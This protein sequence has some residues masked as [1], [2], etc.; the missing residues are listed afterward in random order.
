MKNRP[1]TIREVANILGVS[2][3]TLRRWDQRGSFVPT[4]TAGNQRR[5]TQEQINEFKT[6]SSA[7][8]KADKAKLK[9]AGLEAIH[10]PFFKPET[11][12]EFK[13]AQGLP[14]ALRGLP[15]NSFLKH[16]FLLKHNLGYEADF[17]KDKVEF[18]ESL[19]KS[20]EPPSFARPPLAKL[21]M[22]RVGLA[23]M[24]LVL[25]LSFAGAVLMTRYSVVSGLATRLRQG[26]GGRGEQF[27]KFIENLPHL[28]Q[29]SSGQAKD[30]SFL[31]QDNQAVLAA[32]TGDSD[33]I[34][35]VNVPSFFSQSVGIGTTTVDPA[36]ILD[37][38]SQ[39]KGFLA[40]RMT[41]IQRDAITSPPAGLFV[42]NTDTNHYNMHNGTA[43]QGVFTSIGDSTTGEAFTEEGTS[44]TALYFY[45]TDG[46]GKLT[47]ANLSGARIYTLPDATGTIVT[48][49]NLTA[50]TAVGTITSG[51]WN[52]TA[53]T[54]ANGGT[55]ATTL[56][57]I[58][59]GNGTSPVTALTTS[60]GISGAIS[61]ETGTGAL[62]FGTSPA[63]TT[64]L[65]TAST[66]FALLNTAVTT[67][68][69]AGA[70]TTLSI[71]AATGT[72]T[73]N[74]ATTA[75]TGAL[76]ANGDVTLGNAIT[77][78]ITF[79]GR[80]AADSD[81]IPIGTTG[82][83]DLGSAALPWD[84]LYADNVFAALTGTSG[85]WQRSN[86]AISPTNI[87]DDLLLG[88]TSTSSAKF[89]FIN[90]AG[91]N[92]TA[93]IS[94]NLSLAVPTG[95]AP[96]ATL[97]LFNNG[98]LNIQRSAGGDSGLATTMFFQSNGNV[99]IGTTAPSN[100]GLDVAGA[101]AKIR[102]HDYQDNAD[103]GNFEMFKARGTEVLPAAV[104]NSDQLGVMG[105]LGYDGNSYEFTGYM[106]S[107]VAGAVS[108]GN[109]PGDLRFSTNPTDG[110]VERMRIT[111]SGNMGIGNTTPL[112][113]L[114]VTGT[115]SLS[116]NLSLRGAGTAHT[117]NILDNGTLNFQRYPSGDAA[118]NSSVLF[119]QNNGNVGIGNTAPG[120]MLSV[121]S[122]TPT[123]VSSAGLITVANT[124]D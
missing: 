11:P 55:G 90:M 43:W 77:D 73:L 61:D 88:A 111:S 28:R 8:A 25:I 106:Q 74:N 48:T 20:S 85:Y 50:I 21:N 64:S 114:D 2:T 87:T 57:G 93:T 37:I 80:V 91:G 16:H 47:T 76:T 56:T 110:A 86:N 18:K 13:P 81:L 97:N 83:N 99:G 5:Y 68:N 7:K 92:P 35:N 17:T 40:P 89:G 117:F 120:A 98:T 51:V 38:V 59:L 30:L 66:T 82:T 96:S 69:F 113:A 62:V 63:I 42:Y 26:F 4:R 121:G 10:E 65:T 103:A 3:K 84:N 116:A 105:F 72:V 29:G 101:N 119:L 24:G 60:L 104:Q 27:A 44:G 58:L 46:R 32:A 6:S 70:A 67:I 31:P 124:T 109:V 41:T 107:Y 108:D 49:G 45:D 79:T 19:E 78:N 9:A 53:V 75:I 12:K 94:S 33:L 15:S 36:A 39:D 112:A 95:N 122:S 115:A 52:G 34:L 123:L 14:S 118:N 100:V 22:F 71:G 23:V 102:I 1:Y 54:V